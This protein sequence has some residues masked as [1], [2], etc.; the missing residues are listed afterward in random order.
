[1]LVEQFIEFGYV[2]ATKKKKRSRGSSR[3]SGK[4][5]HRQAVW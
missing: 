1:L 2:I 3:L 5:S 4:G